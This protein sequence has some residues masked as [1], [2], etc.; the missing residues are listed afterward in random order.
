VVWSSPA[1]VTLRTPDDQW[2]VWSLTNLQEKSGT[3]FGQGRSSFLG[4]PAGRLIEYNDELIQFRRIADD[5]VEPFISCRPGD[6]VVVDLSRDGRLLAACGID[7]VTLWDVPTKKSLRSWPI[8]GTGV[9]RHLRICPDAS[10]LV[11]LQSFDGSVEF[12]DVASG[13][14]DSVVGH[15]VRDAVMN[16]SA[17]GRW[18]AT[19]GMGSAIRIYEVRARQEAATLESPLGYVSAIAFSPDQQRLAAGSPK[20]PIQIWDLATHRAVAVLTGHQELVNSLAFLDPNTLVSATRR[21]VRFWKAQ[22]LETLERERSARRAD[23][24]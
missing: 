23:G 8:P 20:G 4:L 24:R 10:C 15:L 16:F 17:D 7:R 1:V 9:G 21:E 2:R 13:R 14:T 3:R 12:F 6:A 19:C 22:P 11:T 5:Q 18:L